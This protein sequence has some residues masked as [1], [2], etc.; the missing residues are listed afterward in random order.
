MS[1]PSPLTYE[2]CHAYF[3]LPVAQAAA[4][5]GVSRPTISKV[6]RARG[7]PRW[8]YRKLRALGKL[9]EWRQRREAAQQAAPTSAISLVLQQSLCSAQQPHSAHS[10]SDALSL[11]VPPLLERELVHEETCQTAF[12]AQEAEPQSLPQLRLLDASERP[13]Y[14]VD[15]DNDDETF[16]VRMLETEDEPDAAANICALDDALPMHPQQFHTD[17][18]PSPDVVPQYDIFRPETQIDQSPLQC[19]EQLNGSP[20]DWECSETLDSIVDEQVDI[21]PLTVG[22]GGVGK[23]S[24]RSLSRPS[25]AT[26]DS[27]NSSGFTVSTKSGVVHRVVLG[28]PNW[29]RGIFS[30]DGHGGLTFRFV[31][32]EPQSCA[33]SEADMFKKGSSLSISESDL[34]EAIGSQI[35]EPVAL[36]QA[37]SLN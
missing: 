6:L 12:G 22:P 9:H 26:E 24:I 16:I 36:T 15:N 19:A 35:E 2:Q 27:D 18:C 8:P 30:S 7:I 25:F 21:P 14:D 23:E 32:N 5:L 33:S 31:G 10:S 20:M 4:A 17:V 13:Y 29:S 1:R 37:D 11:Y 34:Y 3:D 28:E